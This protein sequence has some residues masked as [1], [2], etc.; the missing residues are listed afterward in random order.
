MNKNENSLVKYGLFN[1]FFAK[2][3][4]KSNFNVEIQFWIQFAHPK[5]LK[6]KK[7]HK[8]CKYKL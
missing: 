7:K 8:N 4:F 5:H 1:F 2:Y 3:H 6:S